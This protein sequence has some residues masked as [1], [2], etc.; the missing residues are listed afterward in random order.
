MGRGQEGQGLPWTAGCV[1]F[2][3]DICI[4][5]VPSTNLF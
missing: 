4:L 3:L 5:H 1:L 2:L